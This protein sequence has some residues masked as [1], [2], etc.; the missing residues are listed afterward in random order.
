MENITITIETQPTG[1]R[2][3]LASFAMS[4]MSDSATAD[5]RERQVAIDG[6]T[7]GHLGF[8]A[9]VPG[10]CAWSPPLC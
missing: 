4:A 8:V 2:P 5:V 10:P 6:S 7:K 3:T 9:Y 1:I